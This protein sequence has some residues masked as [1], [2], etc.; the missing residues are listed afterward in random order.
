MIDSALAHLAS[1]LNQMF[2]RRVVLAEDMVVVSNLQEL[3]GGA[4]PSVANKLVLFLGGISRDTAA[5]R[6]RGTI[7][8]EQGSQVSGPEPL[9]LNLLVICAA[10]F[11]GQTYPEALRFLADAITFFQATPVFDHQN[12]PDLDPRIERIVL[13]IENL[14]AGEMHSLWSIHGGHY[15][16][17]VLYRVRLVCLDPGTTQRRDPLVSQPEVGARP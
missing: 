13:N 3:G 9:F 12:T 5:H 16:P 2:R 4:V 11:S 17:S 6:T 14:S 15:L 10:T 7:T 1:Q 8:G